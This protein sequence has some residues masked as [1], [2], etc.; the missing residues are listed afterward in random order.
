MPNKQRFIIDWLHLALQDMRECAEHIAQDD[1]ETARLVVVRIWQ[2]GQSLC[3]LPDRGRP[4]RVP[5]TRELV[6]QGLPY[7]LAY[8]V[9]GKTVQILRVIHTSRQWPC[10]N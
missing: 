6:L 1:P 3:S 2:E 4:G 9:K 10:K 5:G 8:R 7:F